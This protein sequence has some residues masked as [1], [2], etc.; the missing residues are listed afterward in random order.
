MIAL[1]AVV[2][3]L[4][5]CVNVTHQGPIRLIAT[6]GPDTLVGYVVIGPTIERVQAELSELDHGACTG[7]QCWPR[8]AST[9]GQEYLATVAGT[10]CAT[11][12]S[13]SA[14]ITSQAVLLTL[15]SGGGC[16]GAGTQS[17]AQPLSLFSLTRPTR[18]PLPNHIQVTWN[19][20]SNGTTVVGSF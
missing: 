15:K 6:H 4:V 20:E 2:F 5:G 7:P 8:L 12:M 16:G 17:P 18:S 3:G 11:L 10:P 19:G 14:T 9:P 1:L 13:Y